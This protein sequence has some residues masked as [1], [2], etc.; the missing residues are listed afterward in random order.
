MNSIINTKYL[1]KCSNISDIYEHLSTLN[2][3]GKLCNSI[4]ECGTRRVVSTYAFASALL[5]NKN[6]K[7]R[8]IDISSNE[9]IE[10]F[11]KECENE[12]INI[13][14]YKGSDLECPLENTDLLF[15]DTFHVYGQLKRELDKWNVVVNKYILIHD[16]TVDE[17]TSELVRHMKR[18]NIDINSLTYRYNMTYDELY[19]GLWPAIEEFLYNNKNWKLKERFINNNGLTILEKIG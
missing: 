9:Y 16:T 14:F 15:I 11:I 2:K 10:T 1:E 3:Y 6:N 18:D 17:Y 12:N 19:K 4:T 8:I 5:N 7:L 13:N